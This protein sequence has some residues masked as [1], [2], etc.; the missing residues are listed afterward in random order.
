LYLIL[1]RV[2]TIEYMEM[3]FV[4]GGDYTLNSESKDILSTLT[5]NIEH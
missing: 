1:R 2:E 5:H 4:G 3:V